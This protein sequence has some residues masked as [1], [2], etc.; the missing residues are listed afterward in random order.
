MQERRRPLITWIK[1]KMRQINGLR[2]SS[3][4][5]PHTEKSGKK[6][7]CSTPKPMLRSQCIKQ[8]GAAEGDHM[9][10]RLLDPWGS[11]AGKTPA[12]AP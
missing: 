10:P 8:Q 4:H 2:R 11:R 7:F 5:L 12:L 3:N 9:L 6:K 1:A